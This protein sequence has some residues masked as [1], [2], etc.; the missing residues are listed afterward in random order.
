[1]KVN[2]D[3]LEKQTKTIVEENVPLSMNKPKTHDAIVSK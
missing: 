2:I 3:S 1:M